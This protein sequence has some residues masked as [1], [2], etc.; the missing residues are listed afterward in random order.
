MNNCDLKQTDTAVTAC[1]SAQKTADALGKTGAAA[2]KFNELLGFKTNFAALDI[3]TTKRVDFHLRRARRDP[4]MA[5]KE[6]TEEA[7]RKGLSF[8]QYV[9]VKN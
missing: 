4:R 7:R 6:M 3:K 9:N 8:A 1:R 2:D 5:L